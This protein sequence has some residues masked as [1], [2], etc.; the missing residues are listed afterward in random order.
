VI[1]HPVLEQLAAHGVR[2][3][4]ERVRSLLGHLGEPQLACPAVH[5]AGTNGKGSTCMMVSSCLTAAGYRVGTHLSPHLE[6]INERIRFDGIPIDDASLSGFIEA[7]DR[8][9][10][11]WALSS[12]EP[13]APLTYFEF[14]TVLSM[15]AFAARGVDVAVHE[16]GMGGRLDATNVLKP[17]VTAVVTIGLDHIE[18]LG[19]T[20][21][22][23]AAEKAGI[24]KRGVPVVTGL[25]PEDAR[26]VVDAHARRLGCEVWRPGPQ[27]RREFRKDRWSFF[28]PD[29]S[30]LGVDLPL[31]GDHMAHNAMV[32]VGLLHRMR[33][34][35]F[36]IPDD[37]IAEGLRTVDFAG[38]IECPVPG[39]IVD[40]AH[41]VDGAKALAAWLAARPRPERR[42]LLFGIGQGRDPLQIVAPLA[43]HFDEIVTTR[44]N[45]PKAADPMDLAVRLQEGG[46]DVV[47]AA[48]RDIDQDLAEIYV[49]ADETVVAGSLFLAGAARALVRDGA[50]DGLEPGSADLPPDDALGD[51]PFDGE[52]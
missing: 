8:H 29:G 38:R 31:Q 11:D 45:H 44:C 52:E 16:T 4:L 2:M 28:T 41:N 17:V 18:E 51:E 10:M 19:G 23:I 7:L 48:G 6:Q 30:V 1:R 20:I 12:G 39:L 50:L 46:L 21:G 9:R 15:L 32:A 43:D 24:F 37:A 14:M 5:V 25:L 34:L 40:G 49:E 22:L 3:G 33:K 13:H 26:D 35:G 47:L 27:L 42:I 36:H